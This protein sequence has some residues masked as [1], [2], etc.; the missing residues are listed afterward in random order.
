MPPMFEM[1]VLRRAA[2]GVLLLS[3]L[4]CAG[5]QGQPG[6][7][8]EANTGS[9]TGN[10]FEIRLSVKG[11]ELKAVLI[12]RTL[13]E[14]RLLVDAQLQATTLELVSATG[15]L[16][17]PYDSRMIQ[18]NDNTPYCQLF[19]TLAPGKK[20]ELGAVRFQKSRDGYRGAWG[21]FHFD[22]LPAGEYQA[23]ITWQSERS[24]CLDESTRRMRQLP[25]ATKGLVRTTEPLI[26]R[27][28]VRSNQLTLRLR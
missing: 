26:W 8:I 5:T 28:I 15:S 22:E 12:N 13:F 1:Y 16:Q 18:K 4:G 23:R 19:Q 2:L 21:P 9:K 7:S 20:L 6:F 27:G 24:Q 14:Q 11:S 17:K 3:G 25:T 10:P